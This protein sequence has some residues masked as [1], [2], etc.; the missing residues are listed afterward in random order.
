MLEGSDLTVKEITNGCIC[1]TLKG[2]FVDGIKTLVRDY[3]LDRIVI[4]PT[5][6]GKFADILD[7]CRL[8]AMEVPVSV[9]TIMTVAQAPLV[10]AF[11]EVSGISIKSRLKTLRLSF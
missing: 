5:S 4:E 8:A 6:I 9:Q 10:F 1:C 7:A 11:L 2:D 3:R